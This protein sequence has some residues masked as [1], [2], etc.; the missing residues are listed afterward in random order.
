MQTKRD[1]TRTGAAKVITSADEPLC[2][3]CGED[4]GFP[5][6][7]ELPCTTL[8]RLGRHFAD[9]CSKTRT[10]SADRS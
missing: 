5:A 2:P 1:E 10:F 8:S 4:L 9:G 6:V 3:L 7:P